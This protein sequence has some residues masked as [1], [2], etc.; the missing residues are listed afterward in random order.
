MLRPALALAALALA[1][2]GLAATPAVAAPAAGPP[3]VPIGP[4][5]FFSGLVNG[6]A[7]ESTIKV[8]CIGPGSVINGHPVAGQTIGVALLAQPA[9]TG[10][11]YTGDAAKSIDASE[12]VSDTAAP[13]AVFSVYENQPLSTSLVLPCDGTITIV[14]N[15]A[16]NVGGRSSSVLVHLVNVGV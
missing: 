6:V 10:S 14:F 9:P 1:A 4:H 5:Q 15:P 7:T 12:P 13:I 8:V 3:V 11:G 2:T 16:P